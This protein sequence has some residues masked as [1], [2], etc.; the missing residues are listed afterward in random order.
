MSKIVIINAETDEVIER[1]MTK[2][3]KSVVETSNKKHQELFEQREK[4]KAE[5]SAQRLAVLQKLGL[6][7]DEAKILLG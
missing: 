2:E 7:Q 4:E 5:L 3:E 6:T 1:E